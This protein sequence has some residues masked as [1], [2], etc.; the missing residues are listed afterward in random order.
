[1]KVPIK[2][3]DIEVAIIKDLL[4]LNE[5]KTTYEQDQVK[6]ELTGKIQKHAKLAK[7][8]KQVKPYL[9]SPAK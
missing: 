8:K 5:K 6:G 9:E 1:M 7:K 3:K 4:L 2:K